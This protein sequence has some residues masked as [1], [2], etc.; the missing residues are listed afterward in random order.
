MQ[1]VG[2]QRKRPPKGWSSGPIS[3]DLEVLVG[4]PG[5]EPGAP[6]TPCA[7]LGVDHFGP[8]PGT[9]ST[10]NSPQ[11]S[12]MQGVGSRHPPMLACLIIQPCRVDL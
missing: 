4:A 10:E 3:A 6:C 7:L 1:G 8:V 12:G 9:K 11:F 2:V 5:F